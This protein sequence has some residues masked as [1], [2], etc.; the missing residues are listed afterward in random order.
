MG[1]FGTTL[2]GLATSIETALAA[3]QHRRGVSGVRAQLAHGRD[4]LELA[5]CTTFAWI[6]LEQARIAA[7]SPTLAADPARRDGL[8]ATCAHVF[9]HMVPRAE[10]AAGRIAR[11]DVPEFAMTDAMFG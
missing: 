9:A 3:L 8:L 7:A 11:D 4:F 6:W 5:G 1:A 2:A 10:A